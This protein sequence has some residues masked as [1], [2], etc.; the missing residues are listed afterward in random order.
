MKSA[1]EMMSVV[2]SAR[3]AIGEMTS[4]CTCSAGQRAHTGEATGP[5]TWMSSSERRQA[6]LMVI[7]IVSG[8]STE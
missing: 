2:T 4:G 3:P 6:A 5:S 7:S 8:A 1:S